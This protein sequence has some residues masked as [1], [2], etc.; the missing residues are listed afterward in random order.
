MLL[1]P[2]LRDWV[3]KD[4]LVH[5]ILDAVEG[6]DLSGFRVNERGSGSA[7][8]PPSM[9]L[10]LLVYCYATGRFGSRE[11]EGATYRDVAVRYLC[12]GVHPDHDTI[13]TFRRENRG[14]FAACFVKV[15]EMARE[16]G[17]LKVGTVSVDGSKFLADASKHSAVSYRRA[18]EM[19]GQLEMEVA[20]LVKKA[21]GADAT[22]LE[23]G[24]SIPA[25]IALREKRKAALERAR[26]EIEKRAALRAQEQ[27]GDYEKKVAQ[28]Q[29]RRQKGEAVRGREPQP[30]SSVASAKDQYNF[31]DPES[32]MMKAGNGDHFE[33]A[34]NA[35]LAVD[36]EGSMLI[37][38]QRV[39]DQP[40]DKEQLQP[41]VAAIP[42]EVG[43][44]QAVLTDHGFY[45]EKAVE[46]LEADGS[47]QVYA[48]VGKQSH[49]RSVR[50][51]ERRPDAPP[52]P[53]CASGV[54][55]MAHR[56]STSAGRA[57]YGLR[58]QTVE[59][60]FGIIKQ[61]LGFRQF[62]LRGLEKVS[63]EWALVTLAY[64]FKRLQKLMKACSEK[65]KPS[66]IGLQPTQTPT[67][68]LRTAEF[69]AQCLNWVI[70]RF[71]FPSKNIPHSFWNLISK[72][73]PT[74]C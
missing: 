56:I 3:G 25:E 65:S 4:D 27:Q 34:Y 14:L 24:L 1:P 66:P 18:G 64:N 33:Q 38:G 19:I 71:F 20:E 42:A 63:T 67:F 52:P 2:D 41:T 5:F 39:S 74:S 46:K 15:L 35:Q 32:R 7:Q 16:V 29:E 60:V 26:R 58:K 70:N 45:S 13:C 22:P 48:A 28:R 62:R 51:L 21:E 44:P 69:F 17:V 49:H 47:I 68:I 53:A 43:K 50:D 30:P 23:D 59:P 8:Y 72:L 9:M 12:A 55:K 54:E 73:S 40:N 61:V 11:I 57:L 37:V 6:L 31:T 36:A 10:S